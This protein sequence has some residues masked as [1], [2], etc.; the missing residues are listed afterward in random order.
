MDKRRIST[1]IL[2]AAII[3]GAGLLY[4]KARRPAYENPAKNILVKA[5]ENFIIKLDSNPTTGYQW[6]LAQAPDSNILE[7][8]FHE[9]Q[10]SQSKLMGAGGKEAWVF[11]A[12][13]PGKAKLTF[14]YLRPW[15]KS[16]KPVEI[17]EFIIIVGS[18]T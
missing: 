14:Q 6:Q 16:T 15:E 17:T 18:L 10:A 11:K 12:R 9:Y 2:I 4:S 1:I 5:E 7:L 3:T 13:G 8:V